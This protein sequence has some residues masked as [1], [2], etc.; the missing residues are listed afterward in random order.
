MGTSAYQQLKLDVLAVLPIDRNDW[1]ILIGALIVLIFILVPPW[2]RSIRAA[3][4]MLLTALVLG[5]PG[6]SQ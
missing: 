3:F 4:T 1:H 2:R 6:G 5:L